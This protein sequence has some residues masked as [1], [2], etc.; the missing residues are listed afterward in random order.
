MEQN[1][2]P[3]P[4]PGPDQPPAQQQGQQPWSAVPPPAQQ[5]PPAPFASAAREPFYRRHGLGFAITAGVLALVVVSVGVALGAYA[6]TS[7]TSSHS[8]AVARGSGFGAH[9]GIGGRGF[10][11]A[12]RGGV[13]RGTIASISGSTWTVDT[14]A[15]GTVTVEV[16]SSTTFGTPASPERASGFT[17]GESVV[18]VGKRSGTTVTA[19]RVVKASAVIGR[20][21]SQ[22]GSTATPGSGL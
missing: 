4:V 18:V 5:E 1:P 22:P 16:R 19:T 3:P 14:V 8:S 20:P 12:A 13:V 7:A 9:S 21:P 15:G 11:G 6:I 10:P 2:P 17:V